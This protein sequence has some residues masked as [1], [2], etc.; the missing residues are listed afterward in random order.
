MVICQNILTCQIFWD[1]SKLLFGFDLQQF[2]DD[3]MHLYQ[4]VLFYFH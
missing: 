4:R 2:L 1:I 3:I